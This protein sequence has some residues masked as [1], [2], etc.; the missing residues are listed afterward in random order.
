MLTTSNRLQVGQNILARAATGERDQT[1]LR[2][3]EIG[4]RQ[5]T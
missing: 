1:K 5:R 3:A 4:K 2:L